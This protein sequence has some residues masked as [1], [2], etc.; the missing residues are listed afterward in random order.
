MCFIAQSASHAPPSPDTIPAM[1]FQAKF[2]EFKVHGKELVDKVKGLI[3]EGNVRR[4]TPK[5]QGGPAEG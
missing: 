3:H 2:E 5:P 4:V 1:D